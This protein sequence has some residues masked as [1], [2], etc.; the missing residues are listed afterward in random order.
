MVFLPGVDWWAVTAVGMFLLL[1][2]VVAM[3]VRKS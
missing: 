3:M 2:V 1:L